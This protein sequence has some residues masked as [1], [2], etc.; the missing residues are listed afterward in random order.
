MKNHLLLLIFASFFTLIS[1]AKQTRFYGNGDLSCNLIKTI[2][3]DGDGFIWIGT[4]HG[5][6]KFDGWEFSSYYNIENDSTSLS[7]NYVIFLYKDS[8]D[9]LWVASNK[10]LQYYQPYEDRFI[11]IHFPEGAY[12]LVERI[13]ELHNGELWVTSNLGIYSIDKE[14]RQAHPLSEIS[15]LTGTASFGCIYQDRSNSV[16]I[17]FSDRKVLRIVDG[18]TETYQIIDT[19]GSISEFTEDAKGR[20][21]AASYSTI[22]QWE[23]ESRKF[24]SLPN[25]T[26]SFI[27]PQML[28][29]SKGTIYIGSDGQGLRYVDNETMEVKKTKYINRQSVA[30]DNLRI[31]S[32]FEDRNGNIW[33]GCFQRGVLMISSEE[34][35]FHYWDFSAAGQESDITISAFL[36]DRSGRLWVGGDNGQLMEIREDGS[37]KSVWHEGK[38]GVVSL[39]E[40]SENNIWVGRRFGSIFLL[41]K[42]TGEYK[43]VP[44]VQPKYVTWM[45]EGSD[46][47]IYFS[48]F[49]EGLMIYNLRS[50]TWKTITDTTTLN[51]DVKLVNK[52][53]NTMVYDSKDRLWLGHHNGISC[54]DAR[55]N[56]FIELNK[57]I[58][59]ILN[60]VICYAL[61]EDRKGNIWL[62]T[63]Q[64]LYK[65]T[66]YTQELIHYATNKEAPDNVICGLAEDEQGNIW[67]STFKGIRK[68]SPDD[69]SIYSYLS[70]NGLYAKEYTRGIYFQDN[71]GEIYFSS[72]QGITH[73]APGEIQIAGISQQPVLTGLYLNNQSVSTSGLS[74]GHRISPSVLTETSGLV[75]SHNDNTFSLAF[76]TMDFSTPANISFEYRLKD[77]DSHWFILPQGTNL[78]TY[79]NLP[80]GKYTL[81]VRAGKNGVYSP[82]KSLSITIPS[83]WYLSLPLKICY[84]FA[85]AVCI[86]LIAYWQY[87]RLQKRRH[88]E[89]N[90]EKMKFFINIS[91]EIRSPMTLIISPLSMLLKRDYDEV[92][93]KAL[94]SIYQNTN[95]IL[96]LINQMLDMQRI[97]KGQMK[98]MYSEIDL[99]PF[100]RELVDIFK[101]QAQERKINLSFAHHIDSLPVWID[102]NN[103]DKVLVNLIGNA[104]K[105]TDECGDIIVELTQG[106]NIKETG[107]LKRYAEISIT[108]TGVGLDEKT[109]NRIFDRFYQNGTNA[110]FSSGIGLNI[111]KNLVELHHGIITASNREAMRGSCFTIRIPLGNRH[112]KAEELVEQ[113]NSP[114]IVLEQNQSAELIADPKKKAVKSKTR[115]KILIIDDNEEL[116]L[117]LKEELDAIYKVMTCSNAADGLR[118]VLDT[119]PDLIISDVVMPGMDGFALLQKI[120]TNTNI[121]HIPVVL[122]TSK[123]EY[124]N[125]IMGWDK[126]AEA[127][128]TKP[129]NIEELILICSNLIANRMR[130][131]GKFS[132]TQ[133]Q[134]ERAKPV[135]VKSNEEEF[136]ERVMAVI[137]KNIE[138]PSFNVELLAQEVGL[139]RAQ[140]HRR[141]KEL[142]GIPSAEFIRNIRMR[143]AAKL[144]KSQKINVSQ[145][146]YMVGYANPALFSAAF[147]KHYGVSPKEFYKKDGMDEKHT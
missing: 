4:S 140:L 66:P 52:W 87:K 129:F 30:P 27:S 94:H 88:E 80:F 50:D 98:M 49:G 73:F 35:F 95:R 130:L 111:C 43:L 3:Q 5:L 13:I 31:V 79:N 115:N 29:T 104:F 20:L 65:F 122:L 138:N 74:Y 39:L 132:G 107:A 112:L 127:I 89:I 59:A 128:L 147:K 16:W 118:T 137:N 135:E 109:I 139:S 47:N 45:L 141:L 15:D 142:A 97:D 77:T 119:M 2:C 21:F 123:A 116:L 64:G 126:G 78:I 96:T 113:D 7:S 17:P 106:E 133:D 105:F 40:D 62:G 67:C 9:V 108:D 85:F 70:G 28:H 55:H 114:R 84:V 103:F 99:V 8:K 134:E 14:N 37:I 41:N 32:M 60:K 131:K 26:G 93:T 18:S 42:L 90:E 125:R 22:S 51:N 63:N 110:I 86:G 56:R 10:G 48:S 117:Y 69:G 25:E 71:N 82:V 101:Y 46:K 102:R 83:P 143:Y 146:A 136:M 91:H 92:T 121:N 34:S 33:L 100:I 24:I 6:N 36:K 75:L 53:I 23:P 120:K 76:S 58:E 12:P 145:I 57:D 1:Q 19:P 61:I 38:S 81:E 11:S 54:Y 44:E 144:L 124:D 68:V 72:V